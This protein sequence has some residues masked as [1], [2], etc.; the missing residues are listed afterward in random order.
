MDQEVDFETLMEYNTTP[1][2]WEISNNVEQ[3]NSFKKNTAYSS[4][5]DLVEK[6]KEHIKLEGRSNI[7]IA[8]L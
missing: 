2:I 5:E 1:D 3:Y 7:E 4:K 8:C 6:Y